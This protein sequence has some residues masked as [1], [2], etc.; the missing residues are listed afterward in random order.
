MKDGH[1]TNE[2]RFGG[3]L[4]LTPSTREYGKVRD[5]DAG[6]RKIQIEE[7]ERQR[8]LKAES[9]EIWDE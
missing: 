9:K 5:P 7:I 4:M 8:E 6:E 3:G 1:I 2:T